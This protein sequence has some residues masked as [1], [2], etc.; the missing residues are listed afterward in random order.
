MDPFYIAL[1]LY[2]AALVMAVVDLFIPSGGSLAILAVLAATACVLFGFRSSQTMGMAMLTLVIAS[3]PAFAV[4]AIN[5][6]PRTPIGKRVILTTPRAR[7]ARC[8]LEE[9]KQH[10][11]GLVVQ[12]ESPLMPSGQLRISGKRYNATSKGEMIEA[13]QNVEIIDV[14][15]R[16][17]IVRSTTANCTAIPQRAEPEQASDGHA[18]EGKQQR[19]KDGNL[20]DL[21]ADEIGLDSLE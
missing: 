15:Q 11:L 16:N 2:C 6:W 12:L 5:V 19:E 18:T 21:P 4:L 1:L 3:V 9:Q 14:R 7:A 8:A 17:L 10:L 13:G 20:L